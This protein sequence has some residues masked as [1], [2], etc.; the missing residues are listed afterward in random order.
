MLHREC[1]GPRGFYLRSQ[2][3]I[4]IKYSSA[5]L[6]CLLKVLV[7]TDRSVPGKEVISH[8]SWPACQP[9]CCSTGFCCFSGPGAETQLRPRY[10]FQGLMLKGVVVQGLVVLPVARHPGL[11]A[12]V[13]LCTWPVIPTQL[14]PIQRPTTI[15]K[16][17]L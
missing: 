7:S 14:L 6:V 8:C 3:R 15:R 2:G 17:D 10:H 1:T 16:C 9:W 5:F 4:S 11:S 12:L 13:T